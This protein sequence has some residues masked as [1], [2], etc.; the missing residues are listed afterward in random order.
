MSVARV[1]PRLRSGPDFEVPAPGAGVPELMPSA[2]SHAGLSVLCP[3]LPVVSLHGAYH[4][5]LRRRVRRSLAGITGPALLGFSARLAA[6][7]G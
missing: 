3:L 7:R 1:V 6:G 4:F 5:L 2:L